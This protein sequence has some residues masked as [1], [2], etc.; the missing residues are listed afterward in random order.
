MGKRQRIAQRLARKT[1]STPVI[2]QQPQ[3]SSLPEHAEPQ[4]DL[5]IDTSASAVKSD[6]QTAVSVVDSDS[7]QQLKPKTLPLSDAYQQRKAANASRLS[8]FVSVNPERLEEIAFITS[9]EASLDITALPPESR[10]SIVYGAYTYVLGEIDSTYK[11]AW[12][13]KNPAS[14]QLFSELSDR[15]SGKTGVEKLDYLNSLQ[16]HLQTDTVVEKINFG[17]KNALTV[18]ANISAQKDALSPQASALNS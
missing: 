8:F 4:K 17:T 7:S 14:S 13:S 2:D 1:S 18:L 11:Q 10:E 15:L 3:A 12:L 9:V 16:L 5:P 6:P